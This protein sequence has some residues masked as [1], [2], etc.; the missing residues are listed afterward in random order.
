MSTDPTQYADQIYNNTN[1]SVPQDDGAINWTVT[2]LAI[3]SFMMVLCFCVGF[4]WWSYRV[5]R[6]H[7]LR[8]KVQ[9]ENQH[10]VPHGL[11]H[12]QIDPNQVHSISI[13]SSTQ[14]DRGSEISSNTVDNA[15]YEENLSKL[16][17]E[18]SSRGLLART[19][20][21]DSADKT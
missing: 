6:L 3:A 21:T 15:N 11:P 18:H 4:V 5:Y 10:Q 19:Q 16:D 1:I 14:G 20:F 13:V 7:R 8:H 2:A 9:V 12:G 17:R